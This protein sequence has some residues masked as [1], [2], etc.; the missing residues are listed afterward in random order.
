MQITLRGHGRG[1]VNGSEA[2]P[3]SLVGHMVVTFVV[4]SMKFILHTSTTP[5]HTI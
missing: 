3:L 2:M 4:Y 1:F 5:I